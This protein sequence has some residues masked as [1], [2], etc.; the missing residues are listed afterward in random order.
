M[1]PVEFLDSLYPAP[2]G[3]SSYDHLLK[4]RSHLASCGVPGGSK[5]GSVQDL[6]NV[7]GAALSGG[8]RSRVALAAVSYQ[9]PHILVLDG[10]SFI[11]SLLF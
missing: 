4:L 5:D 10:P 3:T 7:V 1:T 11:L 6:Q 2:T 9:K 8:Q